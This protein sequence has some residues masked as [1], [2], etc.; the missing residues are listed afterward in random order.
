MLKSMTGFGASDVED[1]SYKLHVE[2][3]S[4]NQRFLDLD[5][6]MPRMFCA[7]ENELRKLI[8]KQAARGKMDIY[9]TF[10]DKRENQAKV[11]V[12][13]ALA[14]AY[15]SAITEMSEMLCIPNDASASLIS[16]YPDV[17]VVEENTSFTGCDALLYSALEEALGHLNEMRQ[18]EGENIRKDFEARLDI[19]K[20]LV[21]DVSALAPEIVESH[22][23]RM[24]K[25]ISEMLADE[26]ID[27]SRL[28]QETAMYSDRVNYTEEIVRLQSHFVQFSQMLGENV[29]V[30]RK[31]DFLIQEMNREA[32]T[33]GSKA[34]NAKAAQIV[35]D[36]KSEIEK[37]REQVQNIE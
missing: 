30:G 19:L 7:W 34:N 10:R 15:H 26:N 32:N 12:N 18:R 25:A 16:S 29:P 13:Q 23:E 21:N 35:V 20:D 37:L 22:R 1:E 24:R 28:I 17:L 4:V 36:I 6:H 11:R 3:K 8:K 9:V 27:E 5:F 33:I 2:V 14:K 31:L